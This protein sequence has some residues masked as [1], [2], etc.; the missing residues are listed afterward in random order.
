[1]SVA[2]RIDTLVGCFGVGLEPTGSADPFAL[3]RAALSVFRIARERVEF[4]P[5]SHPYHF[6]FD[7]DLRALLE[8][9]VSLY[10]PGVLADPSSLPIKLDE[11]F[12]TRM[13]AF[14]REQA[15]YPGD[16]VE[17]CLAAWEGRS[18]LDLDARIE[19]LRAFRAHPELDSLAVAFKRTFNIAKDAP[20]GDVDPK[21]LEAGAEQVLAE[22][23]GTLRPRI[24][25][26]V[27]ERKYADALALIGKELREPID[28]YFEEVFVMVDDPALRAN[29][30]RLLGQIATAVTRIARFDQLSS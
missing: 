2:D 15:N 16:V 27:T 7:V 30:L 25:A 23:F 6:T 13:R 22:R 18:I 8:R 14:Y 5:S 20:S 21:L 17:A 9:A 24:E 19:A 12:R 28:R 29:R 26:L 10:A 4:A 3:R 1:V 11:F